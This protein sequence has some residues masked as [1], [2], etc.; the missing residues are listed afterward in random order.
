LAAVGPDRD[1][2]TVASPKIVTLPQQSAAFCQKKAESPKKA[3]VAIV[4]GLPCDGV[5]D[6][7]LRVMHVDLRTGGL[8]PGSGSQERWANCIG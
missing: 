3:A 5:K 6:V 2:N 8:Q 4:F 7:N 1:T